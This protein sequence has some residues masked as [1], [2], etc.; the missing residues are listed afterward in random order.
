M[1]ILIDYLVLSIK[2]DTYEELFDQLNMD[3]RDFIEI[4]SY[5]GATNCVYHDGIKV[6]Y[7]VKLEDKGL[8]RNHECIDL[9][10]LDLSGKGCRAVESMN[11][12]D[13]D[14]LGFLKKYD[15][16]F[17]SGNA[18]IARLDIACDDIEGLLDMKKLQE[19][20]YYDKYVCR[21]KNTPDMVIKG[22]ETIYFGSEKSDRRLRIYNKAMEQKVDRHWIRIEFQLRNDNAMSWY[23]NWLNYED[24]IGELFAGVLL[25][26]L[27]F[28]QLPKGMDV[29]TMKEQRHQARLPTVKWWD[30]F[31]NTCTRIPQLYLPGEEYDF[32]R[33]VRS[34]KQNH[35]TTKTMLRLLEVKG[36]TFPDYINEVNRAKHN[37]HQRDL[38]I[39]VGI[40]P[41]E[42][43]TVDDLFPGFKL[44]PIGAY[45]DDIDMPKDD[46]NTAYIKELLRRDRDD[47]SRKV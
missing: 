1:N 22:K 43:I 26:Y 19:Y 36:E 7:N 46:P 38:L 23:L 47:G 40:D 35:S 45:I 9:V 37:R 25:D 39:Q 20:T 27:R 24:R 3:I 42:Q 17:R 10:I 8:G 2:I 15:A 41:D 6:H 5:Y 13:F 29:N 4:K 14:W 28:V 11:N 21:G 30:K 16:M 18:H 44:V 32:N 31:L 12:S 34:D 33:L